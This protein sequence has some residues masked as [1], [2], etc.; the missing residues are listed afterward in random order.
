MGVDAE[1][2]AD[3]DEGYPSHDC[4]WVLEASLTRHEDASGYFRLTTES[5]AMRYVEPPA[6]TTGFPA[7]SMACT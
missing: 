3:Q 4:A 2:R 7:S 1:Q 5:R 6:G